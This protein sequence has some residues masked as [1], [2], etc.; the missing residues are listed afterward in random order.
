MR[1]SP[2]SALPPNNRV[3]HAP[4]ARSTRKVRC[5]LLA[6]HAERW[7]GKENFRA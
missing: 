6:A 3:E 4:V 7:A 5:I 1:A 2:V